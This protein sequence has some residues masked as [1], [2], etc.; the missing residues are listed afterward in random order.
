VPADT[1]ADA[2][3]EPSTPRVE[4]FAESDS[5]GS[6][7]GGRIIR[8]VD[9]RLAREVALKIVG[10][11]DP[12]AVVRLRREAAVLAMLEHPGIVTLYD[13][14]ERD[15]GGL[16][17]ALRIVRGATLA[18]TLEVE[19]AV[20]TR[21]E[22]RRWLEHLLAAADAV[23]H[24][25][26]RG[27]VH[28]DLKP[29]NIMIGEFGETQVIDWGLAA[30]SDS[31]WPPVVPAAASATP[32]APDL[33][34][35]GAVLGTP[36]YMSPEQ[37]R[38]ERVDAR[39]DVWALG[40][41]LY[42][43]LTGHPAFPQLTTVDVLRAVRD[44]CVP[45]SIGSPG[46]ASL[47][48]LYTRA[49]AALDARIP[50]AGAFADSL[51]A[52]LAPPARRARVRAI[53]AALALGLGIVTLATRGTT[54]TA[55]A[56]TRTDV[57]APDNAL[58]DAHATEAQRLLDDEQI[59]EA[60]RLAARS[61][62]L[63]PTP[64]ALGV[65]A[66]TSRGPRPRAEVTAIDTTTC[67]ATDLAPDGRHWLC[68]SERGVTLHVF[69]V[70]EPLWQAPGPHRAALFVGPGV[71]LFAAAGGT[72]GARRDEVR[73]MGRDGRR[74]LDTAVIE[75]TAP[76][77]TNHG[78]PFVHLAGRYCVRVVSA[79][80]LHGADFPGRAIQS[81]GVG[82]DGR[83]TILLLSGALFDAHI[84]Q[85]AATALN[86]IERPR[87]F[88]PTANEV[89][90]IRPLPGGRL[91]LGTVHGSIIVL[92]ASGAEIARTR[93]VP[94]MKITTLAASP[95]GALLALVGERGGPVML[96]AHT[97]RVTT[98][99][100]GADAG[101]VIFADDN[102]IV[103]LGHRLARWSLP[104][105][106][107]S[108]LVGY[109]GIVGL[110]T[111]GD[112]L[113]IAFSSSLAWIDID[114][115][116]ERARI[117]AADPLK[118]VSLAPDGTLIYVG[119]LSTLPTRVA[120]ETLAPLALSSPGL[121]SARRVAH[122]RAGTALVISYAPIAY[123]A[124]PGGATLEPFLTEDVTDIATQADHFALL[125]PHDHALGLFVAAP[126]PLEL[127]RCRDRRALAVALSADADTFYAAHPRDIVA[128]DVASCALTARFDTGGVTPTELVA[129][130]DGVYV[131]AG[132]RDGRVFVWRRDGTLALSL[133]AH[134][135]MV[136]ALAFDPRGR[137]L[138]TGSWDGRTRLLD[139][140]AIERPTAHLVTS[141]RN[142]WGL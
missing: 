127:T 24:A 116:G 51:R 129:S 36:R 109:E 3:I 6:G 102:H 7:S 40:L 98:R 75:C 93:L 74:V 41:M 123:A 60:E 103:T 4:R 110:A 117:V 114:T 44:G 58:A 55:P 99:L 79:R 8:G 137:F 32:S 20:R 113:A 92:D 107:P 69:D 37:A 18:A 130:P 120:P 122:T 49:T 88:G 118:A 108:T 34:H 68:L 28:R 16:Q 57:Q 139:L 23:A 54:P 33:T 17:L 105:A 43:I 136:S 112:A 11:S 38:G 35:P 85:H 21:A 91:A 106:Q 12:D 48:S 19:P 70:A 5:L 71:A 66:A 25:H 27:V 121:T 42:E 1:R 100:P 62:A 78:A 39:A 26:R 13:V 101:G 104:R 124:P 128:L 67:D 45:A 65:L 64:A 30:A 47:A 46:P 53:I 141:V 138:A 82:H 142:A 80:G 140:G 52:A 97:L 84:D 95:S 94:T 15:D 29:A 125:L 14:V 22:I 86:P 133:H 10:G 77:R 87:G 89:A 50:D 90:V 131:S 9:R 119:V 63:S 76:P 56:P 83:V 72:P 115:G 126:A 111:D 96:D 61:L 135:E 134:D 2:T 73:L 59:P 81:V 132:T 31:A